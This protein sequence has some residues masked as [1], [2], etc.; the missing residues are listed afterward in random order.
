MSSLHL[1]LVGDLA[2]FESLHQTWNYALDRSPDKHIFLTWEWQFTWWKHFGQG[3]QLNILVVDD[4]DQ[5]IA[6]APLMRSRYGVGLL[7]IEV[8]E[9]IAYGAGDY[10]GIILRE[11]NDEEAIE[12]VLRYL[13]ME[14]ARANVIVTLPR[15]PK[16]SRLMSFLRDKV[17]LC[18]HAV[19][20][21]EQLAFE[22]PYLSIP[23]DYDAY[24]ALMVRKHDLRR[25][26][27]RLGERCKVDFVYH[28]NSQIK[29]G[30]ESLFELHY[31][32]WER[33]TERMTGL[34]ASPKSRSFCLD[35]TESLDRRGLARLSFLTVDEKPIS[36]VLGFEY[37]ARFYYLKPAFDPEYATYGPGHLHILRLM[38][39]SISNGVTEFDFLRGNEPYKQHWINSSREVVTILL[40]KPGATGRAHLNFL[41]LRQNLRRWGQRQNRASPSLSGVNRH[42][43]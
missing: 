5:T 33:K 9:S 27:K 29:E 22:C 13:A 26:S 12:L 23:S 21:Y 16:D 41:K 30:M 7:G 1:R 6:I 2:E 4:G 18:P 19:A 25:R 15:V 35:V 37:G 24:L 8:I 43:A 39:Q 42:E 28:Q 10:G 17:L 31:G 36:G 14:I 3:K 20:L 40:A 32:R 34:F 11:G 38:E